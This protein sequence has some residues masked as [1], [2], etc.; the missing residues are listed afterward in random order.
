[1]SSNPGGITDTLTCDLSATK[2]NNATLWGIFPIRC[3]AKETRYR[4]LSQ[5]GIHLTHD[6]RFTMPISK[7]FAAGAAAV[8]VAGFADNPPPGMYPMGND[9]GIW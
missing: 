3:N 5:Q 4:V 6:R 9:H 2:L 1:M 8:A 7:K